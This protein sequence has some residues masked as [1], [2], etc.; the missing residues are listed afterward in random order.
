ME[1][2]EVVINLVKKLLHSTLAQGCNNGECR[3]GSRDSP[4]RKATTNRSKRE[5]IIAH[6]ETS[7]IH[8]A[9]RTMILEALVP[10]Q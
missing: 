7:Q 5:T 10:N 8:T 9:I 1:T 4:Q 3:C 2:L 6:S